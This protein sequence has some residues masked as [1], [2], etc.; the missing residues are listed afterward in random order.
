MMIKIVLKYVFIVVLL[1]SN[2]NLWAQEDSLSLN[3]A[4][5]LCRSI[6]SQYTVPTINYEPV[7]PEKFWKKGLLTEFG[8]SQ[9]SLTNWA[10]GG[11]GSVSMNAYFNGHINY[12][13][14]GMFWENRLQLG[15]GFIQSFED[16]Y[17]KSD[18]KFILDSKWGYKG[19]G[20]FYFSAYLNFKSQFTPGYEYP[21]S[22]RVRVSSIFS[23]AY[24]SFGIGLDYKPWDGKMLS[25]NF[26]PISTSW[27]IVTDTL[28]R[29]KYGNAKDETIR[30]ALGA[31]LLVNFE[32]TLFKNFKATS[33][34]SLFSDYL[35]NPWN[36]V[37]NWDVH[38]LYK[39]NKFLTT[40]FRTNMIYDDDILITDKDG[41]QAPRLQFKEILSINFAYTF[42]QF[43]K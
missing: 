1:L 38:L 21:S 14:G 27:V 34:L 31:S 9:I 5:E 35:H 26:A 24:L 4:Q 36:I 23:P 19:F 17:R 41:N 30:Y 10:A 11:S 6:A 43:K 22:G 37:I 42:G 25:V 39:I 18:D 8:F 13:K 28:L 16:G 15:Y 12:E 3:R 29:A 7:V 2:I 33:K 40:S 32:K 20:K